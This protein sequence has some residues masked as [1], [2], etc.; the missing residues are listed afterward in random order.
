[1]KRFAAFALPIGFAVTLA[2]VFLLG[3]ALAWRSQVVLLK[4]RGEIDFLSWSETLRWML[5]D[6]PVY[7][8]RLIE[9]RNPHVALTNTRYVSDAD[10]QRGAELFRQNCSGCHGG[11]GEGVNGPA[12]NQPSQFRSDW[13]LYRTIQRGVPG[14][15]MPP[16]DLADPAIWQIITYLATLAPAEQGSAPE[17]TLADVAFE[18][19]AA[20]A[21]EMDNWMSYSGGY[22]GQRYSSLDQISAAN[23][24]E[25]TLGWVYQ[26]GTRYNKFQVSPIVIDG[27][28]IIS[29]P[30][31]RIVA[32]DAASGAELWT[33]ERAIPDP[34]GLATCC[35]V[36]NRGVAVLDD[37]VFVTT[38]DAHLLALDIRSG[39]LQWETEVADYRLGYTITAAPLAIDGKV[40]T[41]VAG[42]EMAIRG[43]LDA[44]DA[45]TGERVWRFDTVPAPG[46]QGSESWG[47]DLWEIGGA[48][49]W[50]TGSYD[51]ELDLVYWGTSHTVHEPDAD[52][53]SNDK[54][55]GSSMLALR[56]ASGELVWHFQATPD[57]IHG[58]DAAQVPVLADFEVA[59]EQRRLLLNGNRNGFLYRLD[60][61]SGEFLSAEPF[62]RQTWATALNEQGRPELDRAARPSR[63]GTL[64]WPNSLGATNW[65]PPSFNPTTRTLCLPVIDGPSLYYVQ[66]AAYTPG[67]PYVAVVGQ[68]SFNEVAGRFI[69]CLNAADGSLLWDRALTAST[70]SSSTLTMAGLLTTAGNL[71]FA[72]DSRD[73]L[74]LEA[75]SGRELWRLNTGASILAPPVTYRV[76]GRQFVVVASGKALL[77]FTLPDAP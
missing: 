14:T 66:D 17:I 35:G 37:R 15:S 29:E 53:G 51:P 4:A 50:M 3:D 13:A 24:A 40:V 70:G 19:I 25:L 34:D 67:E 2:A 77:A 64:A 49:T 20:R 45:T 61:A 39:R 42:G 75:D 22:A 60:R 58:F 47:N 21:A 59:G 63:G 8:D 52:I 74:V 62:V 46:E 28:M 65:W 6:S 41:G 26:S 7:L 5:P 18:R 48:A 12:L 43:F 31:G 27:V 16:H 30:H 44:Y 38:I 73:F 33:F 9:G 68:Q 69:K 76:G 54:L 57:D 56:G 23:A 10:V 72:A 32:L 36:S 11:G 71:L 55:Y 1:M